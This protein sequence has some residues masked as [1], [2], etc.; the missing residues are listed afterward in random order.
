MKRFDFSMEKILGL[1]EF[2]EEQAKLELGKAVSE[3]NRIRQELEALAAERARMDRVCS[4]SDISDI[5]VNNRYIMRLDMARDR[6]LEELAAAELVVDEKRSV[7]AG[8]MR[9]R[10]VLSNLKERQLAAH[11][12]DLQLAEDDAMDDISSSRSALRPGPNT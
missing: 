12:R 4:E 9:D 11:K 1:R 10:K 3:T 7:F 6:L 8:A 2:K 5:F